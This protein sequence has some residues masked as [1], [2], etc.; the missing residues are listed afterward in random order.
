M[1]TNIW[2]NKNN[3]TRSEASAIIG[4]WRSGADSNVSASI[5]GIH[6]WQVNFIINSYKEDLEDESL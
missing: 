3:V 1:V 2:L 4:F 5:I 6:E